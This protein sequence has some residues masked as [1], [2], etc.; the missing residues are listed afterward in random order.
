MLAGT[1]VVGNDHGDDGD[2][3]SIQAVHLEMAAD[4]AAVGG[5][6]VTRV[7]I[8]ATGGNTWLDPAAALVIAGVVAIHPARL[9]VRIQASLSDR[10]GLAVVV[11]SSAV[12]RPTRRRRRCR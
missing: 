6:A 10:A 12:R 8:D 2:A 3:L 4:A 11:G 7:V 9:L 5:V 1:L